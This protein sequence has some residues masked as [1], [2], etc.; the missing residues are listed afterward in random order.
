MQ[1]VGRRRN[2][3]SCESARESASGHAALGNDLF[4]LGFSCIMTAIRM[5][6]ARAGFRSRAAEPRLIPVGLPH[7]H[8]QSSFGDEE[9]GMVFQFNYAVTFVVVAASTRFRRE[10]L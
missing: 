9:R 5:W 2:L 10:I 8:L 6:V 1:K 4:L 3:D 7:A